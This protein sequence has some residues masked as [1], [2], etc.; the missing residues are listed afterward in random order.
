LNNN[1]SRTQAAELVSRSTGACQYIDP[2]VT[3]FFR[4]G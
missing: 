1:P 3:P 4:A 2:P